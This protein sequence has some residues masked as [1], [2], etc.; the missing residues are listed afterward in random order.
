MRRRV[1]RAMVWLASEL[2]I[3]SWRWAVEA[4]C[5][6]WADLVAWNS[7]CVD[8]EGARQSEWIGTVRI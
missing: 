5:S 3:V 8:E 2:I 1:D 6:W 7:G 4:G